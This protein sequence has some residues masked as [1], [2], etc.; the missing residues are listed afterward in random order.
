MFGL[1]DLKA[2][3][4]PN[5]SLILWFYPWEPEWVSVCCTDPPETGTTLMRGRLRPWHRPSF[6]L[7][8]SPWKM[9][10]S[11]AQ[12]DFFHGAFL[13]CKGSEPQVRG[14][15][16]TYWSS[17]CV[18]GVKPVLLL[19]LLRMFPFPYSPQGFSVGIYFLWQDSL[20]PLHQLPGAWNMPLQWRIL[21]SV[22]A[23][24]WLFMQGWLSHVFLLDESNVL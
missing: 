24:L 19:L 7:P 9:C 16:H 22:T 8:P 15:V 20:L 17:A 3:F 5:N 14:S 6:S 10:K 23:P 11:A 12:R 4:Q 2:L 21:W 1:A 18:W 13:Y